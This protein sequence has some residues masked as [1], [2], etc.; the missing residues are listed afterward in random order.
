MDKLKILFISRAFPPIVGGIE[1]QNYELSLW[2][3]KISRIE[4]IANRFGKKFLPFF[5]PYALVKS[6]FLLKNYD[7]VL[8][9]DA[10]LC[11]LGWILKLVYPKPV[12]SIV[13]GLDLTYPLIIYQQ[14]WVRFFIKKMDKLIA[15]GHETIETGVKRGLPRDKFVF[16]PNGIDIKKFTVWHS[17]QELE[18]IV[19]Q[20]IERKKI[21]FTSGRLAKRKGVA[22]FVS[23]VMPRLGEEF[24]Y[25]IAGNGPDKDTIAETIKDKHLEKR[26]IML[27]YVA[28]SVRNI[29]LGTADLFLQPNIKIAGDMEGFGISVLEAGACRLPVL[30]SN[31]E[32]LK[33]AIKEGWNGFLIEP[34]NADAYLEKINELMSQDDFRLEFGEKARR[35]VEENFSWEKISRQYLEE[36]KNVKLT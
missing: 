32:G 27:G 15:V 24:L 10:V 12:I 23:D 13:H 21:L 17:R 3:K 20:S 35:F 2:L 5:F 19:G 7:V 28:D 11:P 6:L 1:N 25:V 9:G 14:L 31:L 8:L 33:D 36:I 29:L 22:W 30:A 16:V 4:T 26:V 34:E 18:K